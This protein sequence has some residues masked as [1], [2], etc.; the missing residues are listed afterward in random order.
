MNQIV[1]T[2][3]VVGGKPRIDGTRMS[4]LQVAAYHFHVGWP[5]E[6]ISEAFNLTFGQIH[7]ALSYYYA[8]RAEFDQ[9]IQQEFEDIERLEREQQDFA[10]TED[11]LSAVM[12]AAAAA[13]VFKI[14]PRTVRDAIENGKIDA[15]K[16]AG[17]W[18]IR[19]ADAEA[20]WGRRKK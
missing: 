15:L 18:L 7:A 1:S 11:V 13:Q 3:G 10:A 2:P 19:R 17:T 6:E 8:H 12:S 14:D 4:V 9:Q 5:I 16:S 20:R